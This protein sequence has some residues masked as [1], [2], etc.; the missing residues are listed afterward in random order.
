MSE[1]RISVQFPAA[2]HK[3]AWEGIMVILEV[4]EMHVQQLVN[5]VVDR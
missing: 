4:Q 1:Q 3:D 5:T 2:E